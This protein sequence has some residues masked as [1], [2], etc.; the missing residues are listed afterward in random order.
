VKLVATTKLRAL[1]GESIYLY[2]IDN[3]DAG[4]LSMDG[5]ILKL[6]SGSILISGSS[7]LFS[8]TPITIGGSSST[9]SL[10]KSGD[11]INLNVAGVT[12]NYGAVSV[13]NNLSVSGSSIFNGLATFKG[14]ADSGSSG[15]GTVAD[16]AIFIVHPN[17]GGSS[18]IYFKSSQNSPSDY[19]YIR[20]QD[21]TGAA[22][23]EV[24]R[25]TI[26]VEN[27][28]TGTSGPDQIM[29][30][31]YTII[32][33]SNYASTSSADIVSF[34]AGGVE[35]GKISNTGN[36]NLSGTI[37]SSA[38]SGSVLLKHTASEGDHKEILRAYQGA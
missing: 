19:G 31:A 37:I 13:G 29:L 4:T 3:V 16:T 30:K 17:A 14:Q 25:L 11:T 6:D 15:T 10:G 32:N 9:I 5:S 8:T 21:T 20:Y 35:K 24:G 12:Y 27:D 33:G 34:Q 1:D 28:S 26:G 36:L 18:S 2:S 7:L 38:A 22:G 23:T